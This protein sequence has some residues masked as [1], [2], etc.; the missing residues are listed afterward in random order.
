MITVEQQLADAKARAE[1]LE[2]FRQHLLLP[3]YAAIKDD[4]SRG[5]LISVGDVANWLRYVE[6]GTL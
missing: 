4:W 3:Q 2:E 5:D 6:F 1:R